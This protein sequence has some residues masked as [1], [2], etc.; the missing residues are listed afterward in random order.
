MET[1]YELESSSQPLGVSSYAL[2][3]MI[4]DE[5]NGRL[6]TTEKIEAEQAEYE[7]D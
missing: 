2:S 7:K 3:R 6:P 5:V 1:Q 4:P